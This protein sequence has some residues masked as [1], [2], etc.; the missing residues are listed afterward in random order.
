M[1]EQCVCAVQVHGGF[2][3]LESLL[4]GSQDAGPRWPKDRRQNEVKG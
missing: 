2:A 4:T 3:Y 1:R